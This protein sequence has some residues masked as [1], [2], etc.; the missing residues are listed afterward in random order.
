MLSEN[1]L[2]IILSRKKLFKSD[3]IL[4]LDHIEYIESLN[5]AEET[6]P[7]D[8]FDALQNDLKRIIKRLQKELSNMA[9]NKIK[10]I[11]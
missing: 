4:L 3:T 9:K 10:V 5:N 7:N 2:E 8:V 1:E 6:I 11:K